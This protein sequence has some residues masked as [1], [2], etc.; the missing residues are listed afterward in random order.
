MKAKTK[1]VPEYDLD[2]EE[3]YTNLKN[4]KKAKM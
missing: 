2:V 1:E 4:F 3:K